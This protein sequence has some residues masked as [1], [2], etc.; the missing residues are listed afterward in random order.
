MMNSVESRVP[1]LDHRIVEF[2]ATIPQELKIKNY[3]LKYIF[4]QTIKKWIPTEIYNR[5]DKKK[6]FQHPQTNGLRNSTKKSETSF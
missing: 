4:K 3:T 2:S 5:K 1:L 6:A